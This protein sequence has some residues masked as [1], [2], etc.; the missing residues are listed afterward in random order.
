MD[1]RVPYDSW[2]A[3]TEYETQRQENAGGWGKNWK[4]RVGYSDLCM[5]ESIL[6]VVFTPLHT[7]LHSLPELVMNNSQS[8][9]LRGGRDEESQRRL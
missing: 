6:T 5:Q 1:G 8:L 2:L 3:H 4:P 9:V 7:S